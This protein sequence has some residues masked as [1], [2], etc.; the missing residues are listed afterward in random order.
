MV[1]ADHDSRF[2][3]MNWTFSDQTQ[4]TALRSIASP[5]EPRPEMSNPAQPCPRMSNVRVF[6]NLL[7]SSQKA[8][9]EGGKNGE[10]FDCTVWFSDTYVEHSSRMARRIRPVFPAASAISAANLFRAGYEFGPRKRVLQAGVP[11]PRAYAETGEFLGGGGRSPF[12][13]HA[14][15]IGAAQ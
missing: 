13:W 5:S 10:P 15:R 3:S 6:K 4:N 1:V 7:V 11:W 12:D 14:G 8:G 9:D 2:R